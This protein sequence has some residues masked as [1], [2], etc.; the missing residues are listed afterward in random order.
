MSYYSVYIRHCLRFYVRYPNPVFK[1]QSDR[2]DWQACDDAF[3]LLDQ[4]QQE[5]IREIFKSRDT[6]A[7]N[8]YKYATEHNCEQDPIWALVDRVEQ[9]V[10]ER[11]GIRDAL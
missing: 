7:D 4:K 9:L 10:A 8:I 2:R 3:K 5:V 1:T 6:L 11:R